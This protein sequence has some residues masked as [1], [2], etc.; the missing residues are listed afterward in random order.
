MLRP[1]YHIYFIFFFLTVGGA[2]QGSGNRNDLVGKIFIGPE[3]EYIKFIN[4]STLRA[5]VNLYNDTAIFRLIGD[6]L[7]I[8]QRYIQTDGQGRK[9][10]VRY[11]DYLLSAIGKDSFLLK[12]E[13]QDKWLRF[14]H[15]DR[16]KEPVEQ[17]SLLKISFSGPWTSRRWVTIDS[18]GKVT[19]I[20]K[21][22]MY[23][24]E[25]PDGD[26]NA[27]RRYFTGKLTPAAFARFKVLLS[28][29]LPSRIYRFRGCP[30][31]GGYT[32][33]EIRI[34]ASVYTSRGCFLTWPHAFL[35]HYVY[36][37]DEEKGLKNIKHY[38]F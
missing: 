6:T 36:D 18:L 19:F 26:R 24:K 14:M 35:A 23:S 17:F 29:S 32:D 2:G 7:R 28:Q 3:L 5:S 13:G 4:D 25:N 30:I 11:Y 38:A 8:Q 9:D 1:F 31:D 33:F 21:P 37:I 20:D 10:I 15:L 34:G 22:N 16:I 12:G 27:K